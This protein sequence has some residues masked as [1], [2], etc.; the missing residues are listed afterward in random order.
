VLDSSA[1]V[2]DL[3]RATLPP[4]SPPGQLWTVLRWMCIAS[5]LMLT[6]I[7]CGCERIEADSL[8]A[9]RSR[10]RAAIDSIDKHS[11]SIQASSQ[12]SAESLAVIPEKLDATN[13]GLESLGQKVDKLIENTSS[14]RA[15]R[16]E[17]EPPAGS[18]AGSTESPAETVEPPV[19]PGDTIGP[20]SPASLPVESSVRGEASNDITLPD[21][22]VVNARDYIARHFANRFQYEG[23]I[24][25]P[26][27]ALGF[28]PLEI[29]CLTETERHRVYDAWLCGHPP[30]TSAT[31]ITPSLITPPAV[32]ATTPIVT[33]ARIVTPLCPG[34]QCVRPILPT[35]RRGRRR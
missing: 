20:F 1:M 13:R 18:P 31:L 24:T 32:K 12:A 22:T 34:G 9:A 26:L 2:R 25:L 16:A 23:D 21:G 8:E 33:P 3:A 4:P 28:N 29:E 6:F 27:T 7:L 10:Y 11:E 35:T 17:P 19:S 30:A 5:A 14:R 15:L